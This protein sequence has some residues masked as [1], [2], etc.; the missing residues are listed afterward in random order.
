MEEISTVHLELPAAELPVC[1]EKKVIPED[2]MFVLGEHPLAHQTE[3]GYVL[4]IFASPGPSSLPP[5]DHFERNPAQV[6]F[7][8]GT[9]AKPRVAGAE[10]GAKD[11]VAGVHLLPVPLPQS[12][13]MALQT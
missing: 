5:G 10:N 11:A 3:I 7:F 4:L 13:A 6:F 1:P 8:R 12:Q 9:V 2:R